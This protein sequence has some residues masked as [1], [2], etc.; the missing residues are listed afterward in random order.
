MNKHQKM[1]LDN[2]NVFKMLDYAKETKKLNQYNASDV[3][4]YIDTLFSI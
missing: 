3:K 4:Q 1:I 2:V